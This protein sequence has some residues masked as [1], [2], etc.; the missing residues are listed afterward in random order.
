[1]SRAASAAPE[2]EYEFDPELWARVQEHRG[3]W[4]VITDDRIVA[5]EE[6]PEAA[7]KRAADEGEKSPA[8]IYVPE[9]QGTSYL[10]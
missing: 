9:G 5:V 3:K 7:L 1:M 8:L 10:L 6:T 2:L 4:V